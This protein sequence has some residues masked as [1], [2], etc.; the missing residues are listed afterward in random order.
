MSFNGFSDFSR[1][2]GHT[3]WTRDRRPFHTIDPNKRNVCCLVDIQ[4]NVLFKVRDD[5]DT[6]VPH[7]DDRT[8][9]SF[10]TRSCV[11][12]QFVLPKFHSKISNI[13][14]V[15]QCLD[16]P[17]QTETVWKNPVMI[18]QEGL[19]QRWVVGWESKLKEELFVCTTRWSER[20]V[21]PTA[22]TINV[23]RPVLC[24][25][26]RVGNSDILLPPRVGRCI[27]DK[28]LKQQNEGHG[29]SCLAQDGEPPFDRTERTSL[30]FNAQHH[31]R[32]MVHCCSRLVR[33]PWCLK[34]DWLNEGT[35]TA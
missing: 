19:V 7:I 2:L 35:I 11:A 25:S 30:L 34:V 29:V 10:L 15:K 16:I 28:H 33:E 32:T 26:V 23:H 21:I 9:P 18:K 4:H 14:Q 12:Q 5:G 24:F 27:R 8:L 13:F 3:L 17:N 1:V 22:N 31:A 6:V 20:E